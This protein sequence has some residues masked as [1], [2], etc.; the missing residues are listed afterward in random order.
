M[1]YYH[2]ITILKVKLPAFY[3]FNFLFHTHARTHTPSL[4]HHKTFCF[5]SP[6]KLDAVKPCEPH[7]RLFL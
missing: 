2:V 5:M 6:L 1:A 3:Q 7:N 4:R